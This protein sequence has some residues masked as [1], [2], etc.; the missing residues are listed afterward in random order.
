MAAGPPAELD[1]AAP[2]FAYGSNLLTARLRARTP[3]ARPLGVARLPD[4]RLAWHK[5]GDDES[6]K[7]DAAPEPGATVWGVLYVIDASDLPVLDRAE[8]LGRGYAAALVQVHLD[9]MPRAAWTY[10]ACRCDAALRPFAW[11]KDLVLAGAREHGLPDATVHA[12]AAVSAVPDPDAARD[13]AA[14][15]LLPGGRKDGRKVPGCC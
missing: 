1:R 7:C 4:H 15:R 9:G 12:M 14:R 5:I 13:A 11:Y 8:D 10:R 3:S 2:Y 6:G